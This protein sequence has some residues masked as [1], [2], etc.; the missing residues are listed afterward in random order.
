MIDKDD[1][2]RL[3]ELYERS[4]SSSI[5]DEEMEQ[6][7]EL[8]DK[9]PEWEPGTDVVGTLVVNGNGSMTTAAAI[10][11]AA[12]DEDAPIERR[13]AVF[14]QEEL[15]KIARWQNC[16]VKDLP[17]RLI[18][19]RGG[20]YFVL[21][22]EGEYRTSITKAELAV[23][24]P[25]DLARFPSVGGGAEAPDGHIA[26]EKKIGEKI[27]RKSVDDLLDDY[28]SH[29]RPLVVSMLVKRSHFD[30][31]T[32]TFC[33]R[34]CPQRKLQPTFHPQIHH[35][36]TLLGGQRVDRFLD[37]LAAS[38]QLDKPICALYIYGV[39]DVGKTLLASGIAKNWGTAPTKLASACATFNSAIADSPLIFADEEMPESI[40]S[41][42]LRDFVGNSAHSL[43]RKGLPETT[44]FCYFRLIIAAND[45]NILKFEK[46]DINAAGINAIISRVLFIKADPKT[47][48]YIQELGW[49]EGTNDWVD[50]DK[51][52]EHILWLRQERK[53]VAK[54]RYI[55][56]GEQD[57]ARRYIATDSKLRWPVLEFICKSMLGISA[58]GGFTPPPITSKG[59]PRPGETGGVQW[60]NGSIYV[61]VTYTKNNWEQ[62]LGD[63]KIPNINL[64]GRA[65]KPLSIPW[66]SGNDKLDRRL[67]IEGKRLADFYNI[68]PEQVYEA[69][70]LLQ[71]GTAEDFRALV[72]TPRLY[73][74]VGPAP[75][76]KGL[77]AEAAEKAFD[78]AESKKE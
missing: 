63:K 41:S 72:A 77:F 73:V 4:V 76:V 3:A 67:P 28:A 8:V 6:L 36:L 37:W 11:T 30:P 68:D 2:S 66:E 34:A 48:D 33:E 47:A 7:D 64:V 58:G 60:G 5:S 65:L 9:Y 42:F 49:R 21:G 54:S 17:R 15:E 52:A 13:A 69:A 71:I 22:L 70:E 59:A 55:V 53:V 75:V 57:D 40:S 24:L 14:T 44:I 46:E 35:W 27:V 23:S 25:R 74:V 18:I 12:A 43:R 50:G 1:L 32:E 51:I 19:Q 29:A 56:E 62:V 45:P 16:R 26:W 20:V 39:K 31:A 78:K 10:E 38:T 61:N